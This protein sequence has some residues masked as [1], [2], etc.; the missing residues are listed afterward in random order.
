MEPL[1]RPGRPLPVGLRRAAWTILDVV[2]PP[3]CGGCRRL[4]FRLCDECWAAI[5]R[6]P[7]PV[8]LSC[9][10]PVYDDRSGCWCRPVT[11]KLV[12]GIRAAAYYEGP[13]RKAIH[14]LK[15]NNDIGLADALGPL[16]EVCWLTHGLNADLLVPVPLG[17]GRLRKRGYNQAALLAQALG[18]RVGLPVAPWAL[19]RE[20]ETRTQVALD[21]AERYANV[22]GAFRAEPSEVEGRRVALV[23]DVCTTGA[24]LAACAAALREAGA[25]LVWGVA[26]ARPRRDPEIYNFRPGGE[27]DR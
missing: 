11:R 27:H 9:G 2:F 3:R 26:L 23:D 21:W 19:T 22:A 6:L 10:C 16:L 5:H 14:R 8:C 18:T 15:Y 7:L 20:R 1:T 4:G 24:T 13:L 12:N 17:S 25:I